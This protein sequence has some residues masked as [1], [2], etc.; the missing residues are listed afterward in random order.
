[1]DRRDAAGAGIPRIG[2]ANALAVHQDRATGWLVEAG[3]HLD[4]RRLA[5]AIVAQQADDLAGQDRQRDVVERVDAG[6][7]LGDVAQFDKGVVRSIGN[8][9]RDMARRRK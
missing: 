7:A 9:Y 3:E 8:S 4:Q 1:M 6:E 2:E 5:G